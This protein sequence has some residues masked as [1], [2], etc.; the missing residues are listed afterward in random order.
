MGV[1]F[2]HAEGTAIHFSDGISGNAS[3]PYAAVLIQ[4]LI[5][6]V[7]ARI[8]VPL[9]FLISGFLFFASFEF[10]TACIR[11]KL[12]RRIKTLLIPYIAWNVLALAI[13]FLLQSTPW[14]NS[15]FSG[16]SKFIIDYGVYDY[17][18]AFLGI[19][20]TPNSPA[21][22]QFWFIRDLM[23]MV[24]LS[25]LVY[26]TAN[27]FSF[28]GLVLLFGAWFS[29]FK[30]PHFNLSFYAIFFFYSGAVISIK[31]YNLN[32]VDRNGKWI[33]V[34][35]LILAMIDA[36]LQTENLSSGRIQRLILFPGII[37]VWHLAALLARLKRV[38]SLLIRLSGFSFF[39]YAVHE[40]FLLSGLRKIFYRF[41]PPETAL[42][43]ILLYM[44]T[45]LITIF[46][47]ITLA[48]I[49]S[50]LFPTLFKLLTGAR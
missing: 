4:N 43:I 22:Y 37:S 32:W 17:L 36:T 20:L 38:K 27:H 13:Y 7:C 28:G 16:N 12:Q 47:A 35:Y 34:T 21:V 23:I 5:S 44:A 1:I 29:G 15:F 24:I 19:H 30:I 14:F 3:M 48:R 46:S 50:H 33:L 42:E 40:P 6:N 10:S 2:I 45:P 18:N 49:S 41:T 8:S 39:V 31:N 25:P 26:M 11:N 9:F